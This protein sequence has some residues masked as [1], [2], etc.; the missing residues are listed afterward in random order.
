MNSWEVAMTEADQAHPVWRDPIV[1]EVRRVREEMFWI[2][3]TALPG[4][5]STGR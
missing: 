4:W 2:A 1:A 5:A 3:P